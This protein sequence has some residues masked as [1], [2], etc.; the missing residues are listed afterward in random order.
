MNIPNRDDVT[1]LEQLRFAAVL[2]SH[3]RR[4]VQRTGGQDPWVSS[5]YRMGLTCLP[6]LISCSWAKS[7]NLLPVLSSEREKCTVQ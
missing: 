7:H 2:S 3:S 5:M 4:T 1:V 6:A